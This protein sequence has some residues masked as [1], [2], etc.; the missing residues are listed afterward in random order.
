M[1]YLLI[2][3]GPGPEA[4]IVQI[5][6]DPIKQDMPT[7]GFPADIAL[8]ADSSKAIPVLTELV[9]HKA[10]PEQQARF[11]VRSEE[12]RSEHRK[13][14]AEWRDL[15]V[16]KAE[17]RPI[18]AEWLCHCIAE[19]VD[20]DTIIVD[21]AVINSTSV[22]RQVYRTKPGTL[23]GTGGS[24]L[25]W[26]L[27]AA[28]RVGDPARI[29]DKMI[30]ALVGDGAFIEGCP[31]SALWA[32]GISHAPF[33]CVV[34]NNQGYDALKINLRSDYGEHGFWEKRGAEVGLDIAPSPKYALVAQAALGYGQTV[35]DPA[36]LKTA[37]REALD[38]VRGG[39][40]AVLDVRVKST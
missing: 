22:L 3:A 13:L 20:E 10:T 30:V 23:F 14:Q 12:L 1:P 33:L 38:Q 15:A 37:L 28:G 9:R 17:Q 19:V 24:S 26:G 35:D 21:E 11:R 6:I 25:G 8:E 18:S 39:K 31:V 16:S 5:D 36:A 4:K 32:A 27:G 34:F 29:R 2:D 7:W 40:L